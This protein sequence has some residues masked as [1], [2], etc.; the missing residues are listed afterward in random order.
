MKWRLLIQ[1][2][3][4]WIHISFVILFE[5]IKLWC[6][7]NLFGFLFS[8]FFLLQFFCREL[9]S[10][11]GSIQQQTD[12][13]A[14]Q[15]RISLYKFWIE[16]WLPIINLLTSTH[17]LNPFCLNRA[18]YF[19]F[20][21]HRHLNALGVRLKRTSNDVSYDALVLNCAKKEEIFFFQKKGKQMMKIICWQ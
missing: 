4:H 13:A 18:R 17:W 1:K 8:L 5:K 16:L 7:T 21:T 12:R 11:N 14:L 6:V 20:G 10:T 19:Y 9:H 15:R 2:L 3:S